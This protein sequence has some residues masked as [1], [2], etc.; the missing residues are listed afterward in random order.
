MKCE[1]RRIQEQLRRFESNQEKEKFGIVNN[2]RRKVN[3]DEARFENE[4]RCLRPGY[5]RTTN[6]LVLIG[7]NYANSNLSIGGSRENQ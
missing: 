6:S 7:I 2:R 1:K 3:L 5:F 4:M